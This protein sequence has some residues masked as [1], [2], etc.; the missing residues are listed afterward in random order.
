M[1]STYLLFAALMYSRP[2][3]STKDASPP[4]LMSYTS[5][6]GN[7]RHYQTFEGMCRTSFDLP[8]DFRSYEEVRN[9]EDCEE[10]CGPPQNADCRAWEFN[11]EPTLGEARCDIYFSVIT[12]TEYQRDPKRECNMYIEPECMNLPLADIAVRFSFRGQIPDFFIED[13]SPICYWRTNGRPALKNAEDYCAGQHP[14]AHAVSIHS[15][16]ENQIVRQM[17]AGQSTWAKSDNREPCGIGLYEEYSSTEFFTWYDNSEEDFDY[18][19]HGQPGDEGILDESYAGMNECGNNGEWDD[20]HGDELFP[21]V[22][23]VKIQAPTAA[24]VMRRGPDSL[25]ETGPVTSRS[26][27][28]SPVV[29]MFLQ[30]V[31]FVG[32]YD[33]IIP[34]TPTMNDFLTKCSGWMGTFGV[35]C[36]DVSSPSITVTLQGPVRGLS[37]AVDQVINNGFFLD[38]FGSF[39]LTSQVTEAPNTR[40]EIQLDLPFGTNVADPAA[41]LAECSSYLTMFLTATSSCVELRSPDIVVVEAPDDQVGT[42]FDGGITTPAC[43][44]L[45]RRASTAA[46][47]PTTD[48]DDVAQDDNVG[49]LNDITTKTPLT[50]QPGTNDQTQA[51]TE[52]QS[53]SDTD[54]SVELGVSTDVLIVGLVCGALVFCVGILT[55]GYIWS[56]SQEKSKHVFALNNAPLE[57]DLERAEGKTP[58]DTTMPVENSKML[59]V[60]SVGGG[61]MKTKSSSEKVL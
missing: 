34:N 45:R 40:M 57:V 11:L 41:C 31:A 19:R 13:E 7:T 53:S 55:C 32:E 39:I 60:S 24:P 21:V 43:G 42:Y 18:W 15:F 46:P 48:E 29:A 52:N 5:I 58:Q 20:Y 28:P 50:N 51:L 35:S 25:E 16:P 49:V 6:L 33:E 54:S 1:Y 47:A 27:S 56:H 23:K 8:G 38:G 14:G 37:S 59:S 36:I 17:C 12:T 3:T 30:I 2:V 4:R 9:K 10:L 26:P 22:C 44:T 61:K